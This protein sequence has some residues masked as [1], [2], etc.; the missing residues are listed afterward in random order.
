MKMI[1]FTLL[2]FSLSAWS[3]EFQSIDGEEAYLLFQ[4]LKGV[5]CTE[6]NSKDFIVY[7]KYQTTSC[8]ESGSNQNWTCTIQ[9][10]KKDLKKNSYLSASCT[11]EN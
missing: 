9:M 5:V 1:T 7:T 4:S 8:E 2:L 11:R 6:W 10:S 3:S